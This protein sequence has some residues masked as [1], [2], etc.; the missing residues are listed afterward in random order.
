MTRQ[1][2]GFDSR[3]VIV[4]ALIAH[5]IVHD[6]EEKTYYLA[7]S[8]S[9]Q[10]DAYAHDLAVTMEGQNKLLHITWRYQSVIRVKITH[11]TWQF[12]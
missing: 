1:H 2:H 9:G 6:S 5:V 8:V 12:Q 7:L 11:T 10:S 3:V 4:I